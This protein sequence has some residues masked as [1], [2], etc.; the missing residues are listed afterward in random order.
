MTNPSRAATRGRS[1]SPGPGLL[2]QRGILKGESKYYISLAHDDADLRQT[3]GRYVAVRYDDAG[4]AVLVTTLPGVRP[5]RADGPPC[6]LGQSSDGRLDQERDQL[7]LVEMVGHDRPSSL[8][9]AIDQGPDLLRPLET[10]RL[11]RALVLLGSGFVVFS[12]N[13]FL[14]CVP[15]NAAVT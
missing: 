11:K 4:T 5:G 12:R 15:A 1:G 8:M 2:R 14:P 9:G 13:G 7:E 3:G 6:P 10:D